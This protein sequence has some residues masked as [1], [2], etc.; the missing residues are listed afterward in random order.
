MKM[1]ERETKERNELKKSNRQIARQAKPREKGSSKKI[2]AEE[3]DSSEENS[4]KAT[5]TKARQ[6]TNRKKLKKGQRGC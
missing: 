3:A 5:I 6:L 1:E 4:R 2:I